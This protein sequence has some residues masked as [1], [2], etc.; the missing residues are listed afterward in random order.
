MPE[1]IEERLVKENLMDAY[2]R[3]PPYQQNDYL[4]WILKA[5]RPETREKRIAQMLEELRS[6]DRYMGMSYRAR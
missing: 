1:D 5:K 6:G 3:R 4:G 2:R